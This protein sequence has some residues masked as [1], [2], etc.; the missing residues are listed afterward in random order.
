MA[1][2][3]TNTATTGTKARINAIISSALGGPVGVLSTTTDAFAD[4]V[5]GFDVSAEFIAS[6]TGKIDVLLALTPA[7]LGSDTAADFAIRD[8][9]SGASFGRQGDFVRPWCESFTA[10]QSG[11][12]DV[13][14]S[15]D[16]HQSMNRHAA[17]ATAV[18]NLAPALADFQYNWRAALVTAAFFNP[19]KGCTYNACGESYLYQCRYFT[20]NTSTIAAW[21]SRPSGCKSAVTTYIG[22][23]P[24]T[25]NDPHGAMVASVR[26]IMSNP[27][28]GSAVS[29]MPVAND[30]THFRPNSNLVVFFFEIGRASCRE[31]V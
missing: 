21:L 25:C 2:D 10:S 5:L 31:R 13:L 11:A 4:S 12:I 14:F 27:P 15:A 30:A 17:A 22:A 3:A 24:S 16:S 9:A 26:T 29:L 28:T 8:L 7:T 6:A 19:S 23:S 20:S 1:T 18:A